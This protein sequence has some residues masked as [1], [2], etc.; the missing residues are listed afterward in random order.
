M[1]ISS[2]VLNG[3][4]DCAGAFLF[5]NLCFQIEVANQAMHV[6]SVYS[7]DRNCSPA[8]LAGRNPKADKARPAQ[9]VFRHKPSA[10][11]SGPKT[12]RA[13]PVQQSAPPSPRVNVVA[14]LYTQT[15]VKRH[16]QCKNPGIKVRLQHFR[17]YR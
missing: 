17:E 14:V 13:P 7:Q 8:A 4:T 16:T 2:L 6:I 3:H 11:Q 5:L 9:W 15:I 12:E 1:G 10:H